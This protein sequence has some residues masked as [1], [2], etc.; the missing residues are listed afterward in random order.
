[1]Q[2]A[3]LTFTFS[4]DGKELSPATQPREQNAL[5]LMPQAASG[6]ASTAPTRSDRRYAP[7]EIHQPVNGTDT[8][9]PYAIAIGQSPRF[10][11]PVVQPGESVGIDLLI[12]PRRRHWRQR[13][14]RFQIY[15]EPKGYGAGWQCK[16]DVE[17]I[18]FGGLRR[19]VRIDQVTSAAAPPASQSSS[20]TATQRAASVG[21]G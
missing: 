19:P 16:S 10:V 11:T 15:S 13:N 7:Y 21:A 8:S 1:V 12:R 18:R 5:T 20:Q 14:Y 6:A 4:A 9:D 2:P 3:V 17:T